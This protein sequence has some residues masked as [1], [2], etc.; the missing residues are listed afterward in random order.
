MNKITKTMTN[1]QIYRIAMGFYK[2]FNGD[3]ILPIKVNFYLVKNKNHFLQLGQQIE[4]FKDK[5]CGDYDK[6]E[7]INQK[8]KELSELEEEVSFYQVSLED[9]GDI[10]LSMEQ[11]DTLEF[12]IKEE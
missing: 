2:Y 12:M 8:L 11:L 1:E 3:L 7:V 5:I 6:E 4:E 9:F 10:N